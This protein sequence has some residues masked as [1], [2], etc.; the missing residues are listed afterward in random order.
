MHMKQS[1]L[2]LLA[3]LC[4][5]FTA[6]TS[7]ESALKKYAVSVAETRLNDTLTKE[8]ADGITNSQWIQQSYREYIFNRSKFEAM[9]VKFQGE[10]S[11]TVT[12][13]T[14]TYSTKLRQTLVGIAAKAD[15]SKKLFNFGDAI[16][17]VGRQTGQSVGIDEHTPIVIKFS[18]NGGQWVEDGK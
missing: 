3:G 15:G 13:V 7:K 16:K 12:V 10:N 17:A 2:V 14:S 1:I 5:F 8:A 9:D 18:R 11:A 6:C 4:L